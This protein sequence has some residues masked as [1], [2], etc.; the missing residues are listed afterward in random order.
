MPRT[1]RKRP[2]LSL[3]SRATISAAVIATMVLWLSGARAF[4]SNAAFNFL[5]TANTIIGASVTT[6]STDDTLINQM[7]PG[8]GNQL[9][10]AD[11]SALLASDVSG[12]VVTDNTVVGTQD[13]TGAIQ[14]NQDGMV[15]ADTLSDV[16]LEVGASAEGTTTVD[17]EIGGVGNQAIDSEAE[18]AGLVGSILGVETTTDIDVDQTTDADQSNQLA[19]VVAEGVSDVEQTVASD[20]LGIVVLTQDIG[21]TGNQAV[22]NDTGVLDVVVAAQEILN[23]I[24]VAVTQDCG[25]TCNQDAVADVTG[26][27]DGTQ[28]VTGSAAGL[29]VIGQSTNGAGNQEVD[30]GSAALSVIFAGQELL[31]LTEIVLEQEGDGTANQAAEVNADSE[32][33]ADQ[34]AESAAADVNLIG[35]SNNGT[36]ANQQIAN[37]SVA[38]DQVAAV[39]AALVANIV[40]SSMDVDGTANQDLVADLSVEAD[41]D[42]EVTGDALAFNV[43]GQENDGTSANQEIDNAAFAVDATSGVQGIAGVNAF[44]SEMEA[45]G[46][47]NQMADAT[48]EA[49]V[50]GDLTVTGPALSIVLAGQSNDGTNANQ[51]LSNVSGASDT[52][53]GVQSVAAANTASNT[54]TNDDG[55]ANMD[56]T[57]DAESDA[58]GDADVAGTAASL[59][60]LGQE[61]D[62]TNANQEIDTESSAEDQVLA[63]QGVTGTNI[64]TS[65]MENDDGSANMD[66][67]GDLDSDVD[68]ELDASGSAV[69]GQGVS[70]ENDGTNANQ[71]VEA[72]SAAVSGVLAG[73]TLVGINAAGASMVNDDGSLNAEQD[74]DMN[75]DM[76]GEADVS[77]EATSGNGVS[78]ENDGTNAN[79]GA[80]VESLAGSQALGAQTMLGVNAAEMSI[81]NDD[82]SFN[83]ALD[84]DL[85]M[86]MDGELSVESSADSSNEVS[87]ENDGINANQGAES[88][89][90]ALDAAGGIQTVIGTNGVAMAIENDDG[91]ANA[92]VDADLEAD[93]DADMDVTGESASVSEVSQDNDGMNANQAAA[94]AAVAQD[95]VFGAQTAF[96]VNTADVSVENDDGNFNG[97]VDLSLDAD[98]DA[99]MSLEGPA[100]AESTI[101]QTNDGEDAN[102]DAESAAVAVDGVLGTQVVFSGNAAAIDMDAGDGNANVAVDTEMDAVAN[103][104]TDMTGEA[105]AIS[106]VTQENDGEDAN[107]DAASAAVAQDVV[108]GS[109]TV[110]AGNALAVTTDAGNGSSNTLVDADMDAEANAEQELD[111]SATAENSIGQDNDGEMANQSAEA[112]TAATDLVVGEQNAGAANV[113]DIDTTCDGPVCADASTIDVI[114]ASDADQDIDADADATTDLSQASDGD[115]GSNQGATTGTLAESAALGSQNNGATN[116]IGVTKVC[117]GLV[118]AQLVD[119]S[120]IAAATAEQDVEATSD[121]ETTGTQT[122]DGNGGANQ[123]MDATTTSGAAALGEQNNVAENNVVIEEECNA[124]V[125]AQAVISDTAA[126][127]AADQDVSADSDANTDIVQDA[128]GD[129]GANQN[130]TGTTDSEATAAAAQNNLA[131]D[132]VTV[133]QGC[134]GSVCAQGAFITSGAVAAANQEVNAESEADSS[135]EQLADGTGGANQDADMD[136]ESNTTLAAGQNNEAGSN[137]TL[138]QDCNSAVCGQGATVDQGAIAISNQEVNGTSEATNEVVQ[139]AD[140]PGGA[141]QTADGTTAASTTMGG[142]QNT[143]AD[144]TTAVDQTAGGV[145]NQAANV[146][147]GS[148]TVSNFTITGGSTSNTVITQTKN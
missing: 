49:D 144:T 75:N 2:G 36:A 90:V 113:V 143:T 33:N 39:Q 80:S 19:D 20:A 106:T 7:V 145:A 13:D 72:G 59:V 76:D 131:F 101:E 22:A 122:A 46:P 105:E 102:Q 66:F 14:S 73:Q 45:D 43:L 132:N 27:I 142:S 28:D 140:G 126:V 35:Q 104:D 10:D 55:P 78:Q 100:T 135:V 88:A 77:A 23:G 108:L 1:Q 52:V 47:A 50:E 41:A 114:A 21:G 97:N 89:A 12:N 26:V 95:S 120:A 133:D 86:D 38:A 25:D 118:C 98:T 137:V 134:T 15:E 146:T 48:L 129:G 141:N 115:G 69:S 63:L 29:N 109:Q 121:A 64:V 116:T 40:D 91:S 4:A 17:Q 9:A 127:A 61:N 3:P 119:L 74:V 147:G 44:T 110:T 84:A 107:Q 24:D 136:A 139:D 65:V 79:Q 96:G 8:V 138:N 123:D 93:V 87:Q 51:Q 54:M 94:S 31:G 34:T 6:G 11:T 83:G 56:F 99:T 16:A 130:A 60:L 124:L 42:S 58:S 18:V 37:E 112:E 92:D 128:D 148:F 70:Q 81:E 103:G 82:G 57:A 30:N 111:G 62:G 68:G 53:A 117:A 32:L 125:C 85:E 71:G 67:N 5:S